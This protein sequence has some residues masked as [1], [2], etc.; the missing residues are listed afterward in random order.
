L[1]ESD[2]Y[3]QSSGHGRLVLHSSATSVVCRAPGA[4]RAHLLQ[5]QNGE[6]ERSKYETVCGRSTG[7]VFDELGIGR[8]NRRRSVV[9]I[10]AERVSICRLRN[11]RRTTRLMSLVS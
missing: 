6:A 2:V 11:V 9:R 8:R 10:T 7:G 5:F 3:L 1:L 4:V